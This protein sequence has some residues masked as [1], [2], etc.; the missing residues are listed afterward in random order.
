MQCLLSTNYVPDPMTNAKDSI[1]RK[2][3]IVHDFMEL[4]I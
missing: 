1:V 2:A 4:T 3:D